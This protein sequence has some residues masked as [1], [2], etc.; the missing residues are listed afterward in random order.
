VLARVWAQGSR[1]PVTTELPSAVRTRMDETLPFVHWAL[2]CAAASF[3]DQS[4][5]SI[6]LWV[7]LRTRP[8]E[9]VKCTIGGRVVRSPVVFP[10]LG[11]VN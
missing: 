5:A 2:F 7:P 6:H 1:F 9:S 10:N 11:C 3:S 4:D 8:C